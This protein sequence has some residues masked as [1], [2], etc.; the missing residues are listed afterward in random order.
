MYKFHR[1]PYTYEPGVTRSLSYTKQNRC[2]ITEQDPKQIR[3]PVPTPTP[4][5]TPGFS[6]F[7][8]TLIPTSTPVRRDWSWPVVPMPTR[9]FLWYPG[10][11]PFKPAVYSTGSKIMFPFVDMFTPLPLGL[12]PVEPVSPIYEAFPLSTTSVPVSVIQRTV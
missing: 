10:S 11:S 5:T 12:K 9:P 8:S 2:V 4:H 7:P 1:L 3:K 6:S